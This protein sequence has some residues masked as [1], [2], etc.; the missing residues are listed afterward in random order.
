IGRDISMLV[1]RPGRRFGVR[2]VETAERHEPQ[3]RA[4]QRHGDLVTA[5]LTRTPTQRFENADRAE[6]TDHVV[7]DRYDWRRMRTLERAFGG[8]K[9]G[10]R[11][12]DL[13]KADTVL[14]RTCVAV[15]YNARVDDP[16][17][18]CSQRLGV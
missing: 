10:N 1:G 9:P 7:D 15:Q 13:V 8:E 11:R 12:A 14:P 4:G 2:L 6:P 17:P 16:G 18:L 5:S 3:H